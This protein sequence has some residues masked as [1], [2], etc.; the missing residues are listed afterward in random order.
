MS[1]WLGSTLMFLQW[2]GGNKSGRSCVPVS[3][4][5]IG[6]SWVWIWTSFTLPCT[7]LSH[8]L[9]LDPVSCWREIPCSSVV[10]NNDVASL[11]QWC[12]RYPNPLYLFSCRVGNLPPTAHGSAIQLRRLDWTQT[13]CCFSIGCIYRWLVDS[14]MFYPTEGPIV[15]LSASGENPNTTK[16]KLI[17]PF[18]HSWA[19][20]GDIWGMT[21]MAFWKSFL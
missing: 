12:H 10:H 11:G 18:G 2:A 3:H 20:M 13:H 5:S 9:F 19:F 8:D 16:R 15:P 14:Q 6:M 1:K 7:K 4:L 21:L 17:K